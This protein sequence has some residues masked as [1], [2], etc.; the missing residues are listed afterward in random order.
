M[1]EIYMKIEKEIELERRMTRVE[2]KLDEITNNHLVHLS[3]DLEKL[4]DKLGNINIKLAYWS[5]GIV[6]ATYLVDKI[7]K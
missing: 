1:T 6:V 4:S 2:T 3:A 5:G 7:L